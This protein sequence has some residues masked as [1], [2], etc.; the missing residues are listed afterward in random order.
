MP[1]TKEQ[2]AEGAKNARLLRFFRI[3]LAEYKQV[4]DF[5]AT[6]LCKVGNVTTKSGALSMGILLG[7]T[8]RALDHN[9]QTGQLRGIL[10]WRI[11]RALGLI[12]NAF[13]EKTAEVLHA[14]A[15]YLN[16]PPVTTVL[17]PRFGIIGKAKKKKK[18]IFGSPN[19]PILPEKKVRGKC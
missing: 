18:M 2:K 16:Y 14:L 5:Q 12:E 7:T 11:N 6:N 8:R 9:H 15:Y 17:G 10:D 3:S 13:H 19:G 1:K 4:E